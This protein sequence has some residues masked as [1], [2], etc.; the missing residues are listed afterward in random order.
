MSVPELLNYTHNN[1]ITMLCVKRSQD[2]PR[3]ITTLIENNA[4]DRAFLEI[5]M[6][7]FLQLAATSTPHWSEV[8]YLVGLPCIHFYFESI[9][10]ECL[11]GTLPPL[12]VCTRM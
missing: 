1:V 11:V 3:A 10:P 12:S 9:S 7:D 5:G 8:Y 2:I 4:T 6:N